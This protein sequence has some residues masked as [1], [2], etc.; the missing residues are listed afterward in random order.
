[1]K[2]DILAIDVGTTAF[3]MGVFSPDLE[4]RCEASREYEINLYDRGLTPGRRG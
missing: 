1:M 4:K 3:K 2:K